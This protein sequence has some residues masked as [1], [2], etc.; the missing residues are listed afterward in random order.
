VR[1]KYVDNNTKPGGFVNY[2]PKRGGDYNRAGE[3]QATKKYRVAG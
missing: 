1:Y 2:S 3:V